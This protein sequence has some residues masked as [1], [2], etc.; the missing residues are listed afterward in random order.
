MK[1]SFHSD[2]VSHFTPSRFAMKIFAV[3]IFVLCILSQFAISVDFEDITNDMI[4]E[5][6]NKLDP[7]AKVKFGLTRKRAREVVKSTPREILA[8]IAD[9]VCKDRGYCYYSMRDRLSMTNIPGISA[10]DFKFISN[11]KMIDTENVPQVVE[12]ISRLKNVLVEKAESYEENPE[13]DRRCDDG[14]DTTIESRIHVSMY[15]NFAKYNNE[16]VIACLNNISEKIMEKC[17]HDNGMKQVCSLYSTM[18]GLEY[19]GSWINPIIG[20]K[21]FF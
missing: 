16:E 18:C 19:D 5:I 21:L 3:A 12:E 1:E 14:G 2:C 11:S 4:I 10:D 9:K 15:G 13:L 7:E 6:G 8:Y 20:C 17:V